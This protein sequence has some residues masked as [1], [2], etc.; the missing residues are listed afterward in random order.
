MTF[1]IRNAYLAFVLLVASIGT[2]SALEVVIRR[3]IEY[4]DHDGVKLRGD[5]YRPREVSKA[6]VLIAVHGGGWQSGSPQFYRYWGPYL[7]AN[8]YAVFAIEY[9]LSKPGK[10]S[11]PAA[12]YDVKAAVQFV[13]AKA[14]SLNV[15]PERIGL[16]GDEAGAHLASLV[17][18][19]GGDPIF[20]SEYKNAPNA[21]TP[22]H[23]KAGV[24]FYGL[25][26][27]LAQ[28]THDQTFRPLD[29]I[30]EKFLGA[31]PM[32]SRQKYFDASPISYA[33][34][35]KNKPRFQI[36]YGTSDEIADVST[37]SLAFLTALKQA[38]FFVRKIE[39]PS[40]GNF[41]V[42]DPFS[43]P[44]SPNAYTG[45]RLLRFLAGAFGPAD[46]ELAPE[47]Q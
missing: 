3:G 2:A 6:P 35:D 14:V 23:V 44:A 27:L 10:P 19:A 16:M 12:V 28:W 9:R 32:Q 45:P 26:D 25:F 37:Q 34:L 11:Y 17:A 46:R 5:L 29:Q 24:A 38:Q 40:V 4:V 39:I 7:A 41:W 21:A 13:R 22:V 20:S 47:T 42:S 43:D 18:L 33:T 30:S 8:G 1:R 31:S 15:D 36:I